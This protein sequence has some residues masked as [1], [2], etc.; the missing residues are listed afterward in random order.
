MLEDNPFPLAEE[1]LEKIKRKGGKRAVWIVGDK[2]VQT[3]SDTWNIDKM[4]ATG[5]KLVGVFD[6]RVSHLDLAEDIIAADC[7]E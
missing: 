4:E 1:T 2:I 7:E 3:K 6:R 5:A